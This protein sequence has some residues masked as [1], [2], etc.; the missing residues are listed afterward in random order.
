MGKIVNVNVYLEDDEI[1]FLEWL[2]NYTTIKYGDS[3]STVES[4]I[5]AMA[6][7]YIH[8]RMNDYKERGLYREEEYKC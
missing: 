6:G 2:V 7:T 5:D 1:K 3:F 8:E 4:K